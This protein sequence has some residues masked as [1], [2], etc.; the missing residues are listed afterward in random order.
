MSVCSTLRRSCYDEVQDI[1]AQVIGGEVP[2]LPDLQQQQGH[3]RQGA[4]SDSA[5]TVP[6]VLPVLQDAV[7]DRLQG[8][9]RD[10]H[11]DTDTDGDA[12]INRI[13]YRFP[14]SAP[15]AWGRYFF[16]GTTGGD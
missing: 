5:H 1:R 11:G 7:H 10:R 15:E 14:P 12:R 3:D 6:G 13:K 8:R 16:A 2:D 4:P 9:D